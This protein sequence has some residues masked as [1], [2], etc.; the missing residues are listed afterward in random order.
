MLEL[1]TGLEINTELSE[2]LTLHI[3][4][5][6]TIAANELLSVLRRC[7]DGGPAMS[8]SI[9]DHWLTATEN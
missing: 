7:V 5:L 3:G 1:A 2:V 6:T 4:R 8:I 9:W